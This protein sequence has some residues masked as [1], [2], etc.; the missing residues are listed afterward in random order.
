MINIGE[1]STT[2]LWKK[3]QIYKKFDEL[4]NTN[5]RWS[6]WGEWIKEP[7]GPYLVC[8]CVREV[9]GDLETLYE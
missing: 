3:T 5:F 2:I 7:P 6:R 8:V 9:H 1:I 4:L